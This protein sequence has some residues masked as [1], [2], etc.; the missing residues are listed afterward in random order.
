MRF[1]LIGKWGEIYDF[2]KEIYKKEIRERG[3]GEEG[4]MERIGGIME[5]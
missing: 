3:M 2:K 1:D 5:K 4:E